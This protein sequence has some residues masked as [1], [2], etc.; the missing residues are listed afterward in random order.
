MVAHSALTP[1]GPQALP[2]EH[3]RWAEAVWNRIDR[4]SNEAV[5][6]QE[7]C[8]DEF[9]T[10]LRSILAPQ[11]LGMRA[12]TYGRAEVNLQQLLIYVL[13]KAD[14]NHDGKLNFE[15]FVA[16][17]ETL[18]SHNVT[19]ATD[20]VFALFDLD[21]DQHLDMDEFREVCRYFLGR[22]PTEPEFLA[23]WQR[24]DALG[25]GRVSKEQYMKWLRGSA[26]SRIRR[27]T[28]RLDKIDAVTGLHRTRSVARSKLIHRPAPGLIPR[29]CEPSLQPAWNSRWSNKD[30]SEQNLAYRGNNQAITFFSRPLSLPE[31]RR[32]YRTYSGFDHNLAKL[33]FPEPV[34][35]K[36]VLSTD[37]VVALSMAGSDRHIPGGKMRNFKGEEVPWQEQTPRALKKQVWEPGSLLLRVPA[38]PAPHLVHGR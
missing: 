4:D 23:E 32:F 25:N 6:L 10:V 34:K 5:T 11:T 13:R 36:P 24:L 9:Q 15:E 31:L 16:F 33:E 30:T 35:P 8:C 14:V 29:T 38:P 2:E 37:S 27:E 22:R 1:P 19:E 28:A 12:V 21:C 26:S 17:T 20:I 7:L 3:K 18:R